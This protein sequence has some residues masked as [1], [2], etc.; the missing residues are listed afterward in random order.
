MRLV[1][2]VTAISVFSLI[3]VTIVWKTSKNKTLLASSA[4]PIELAKKQSD[5]AENTSIVV[6]LD[7]QQ[8]Q[9]ESHW[10]NGA[11]RRL[12]DHFLIQYQD[13][14]NAMWTAFNQHCQSLDYC[15]PLTHLFK[16]YITYKL[17]LTDIDHGEINSPDAF[18]DRIETLADLRAL[19]FNLQE[20]LAL[21][22]D[23]TVWD[24]HAA[25]R[26][27]IYHDAA[28]TSDE[29]AR[30][31]EQHYASLPDD[32]RAAVAPTLA[33]QT[34]QTLKVKKSDQY[35]VLAAQ[36][37]HEATERL[38]STYA[39]Q[40]EWKTRVTL[41][42]EE[43]KHLKTHVTEDPDYLNQ[44]IEELRT[45]LFNQSEQK[46]LAVFVANPVLLKP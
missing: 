8:H 22:G 45:R 7:G 20:R 34:L 36:F 40:N 16:R 26:M 31:L 23:D 3:V 14:E 15:Q 32:Q 35:N 4:Q 25:N 33:L 42:L 17:A 41:Y 9:S 21:F 44:Q 12:F 24:K 2:I 6:E 18:R 37:G 39:K 19:H 29:K 46:R 28:L 5:N 38:I 27:D 11:V 30:L 1:S 13:G 10:L 43:V